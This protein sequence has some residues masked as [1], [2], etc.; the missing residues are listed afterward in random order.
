MY[1]DDV[2]GGGRCQR[3][4]AAVPRSLVPGCTPSSRA[5][6]KRLTW[7]ND[8][9]R[10]AVLGLFSWF[11]QYMEMLD[12]SGMRSGAAWRLRAS[13]LFAVMN[14]LDHSVSVHYFFGLHIPRDLLIA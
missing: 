8:D 14:M 12:N 4:L 3:R 6:R 1:A 10:E 13:S 5:H 2:F 9:R 7:A 11:V